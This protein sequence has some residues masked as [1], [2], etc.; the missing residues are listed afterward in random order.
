[1]IAKYLEFGCRAVSVPD[2]MMNLCATFSKGKIIHNGPKKIDSN[3]LTD[4]KSLEQFN[5]DVS[6]KSKIPEGASNQAFA[7]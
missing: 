6:E 5:E 7:E 1:L 4:D 3:N 2:N